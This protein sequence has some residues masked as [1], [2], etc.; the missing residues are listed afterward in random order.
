MVGKGQEKNYSG[1]CSMGK[2]SMQKE[3]QEKVMC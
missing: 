2:T 1:N 3:K